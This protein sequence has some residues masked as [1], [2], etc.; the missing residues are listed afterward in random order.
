[1]KIVV[2]GAML[3]ELSFIQNQLEVTARSTLGGMKIYEGYFK[4][5][6]VVAVQSNIGK[7][8]AAA[9]ATLAI[10]LYKPSCIINIGT[11]ATLDN[12]L[13]IGSIILSQST[14][15]HD[16]DA[17]H[18]GY[19]YGQL[20]Q[21]P[22]DYQADKKLLELFETTAQKKNLLFRRGIIVTGDQ[23]V[24]S[25]TA[26]HLIKTKFPDAIGIDMETAAIAQVA[27]L[28]EIPFISV[29]GITDNANEE[30]QQAFCNNLVNVAD[31]VGD[32]ALAAMISYL[33][34]MCR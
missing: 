17:A 20:P 1:M 4:K 22:A 11:L 24:A 9:A 14:V 33:Y 8:N 23:F 30:S 6:E 26:L 13:Q 32:L 19:A 15:Y 18:L 2:I 25:A 28:F 29:R 10:H 31:S 7:V 34:C 5:L 16:V 12:T 3:E 27:H 21:M